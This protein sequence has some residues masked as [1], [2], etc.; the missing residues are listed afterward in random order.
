MA[1]KAKVPTKRIK[2][3][4]KGLRKGLKKEVA[5][6]K[7]AQKKG[8]QTARKVA[9]NSKELI[10]LKK[11]LEA[12]KKKKRRAGLSDYN[13]FMRA[14]IKKGKSFKQAAA[15]WRK[16]K[17]QAAKKLRRPSSYNVFVSMELKR[18]KTM[19]QAIRA[20]NLLK[21]PPKKRRKKPVKKKVVRS[22]IVVR[23][24]KPIVR[25]IVRMSKPK[26]ITRIRRIVS[27]PVV[28][29]K[30][31]FPERKIVAIIKEAMAQSRTNT[32]KSSES[33][34]RIFSEGIP[35]DEEL[36]LDLLELYYSEVAR[37]GVK[38]SL[39]LDEI[40][41]SFFYSLARI[42]RKGI[43]LKEFEEIAKKN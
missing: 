13:R 36:A 41:N 39:N 20:W 18:G 7:K 2:R 22:K 3:E 43:E 32:V 15:I 5:K 29:T 42:Q 28:V 24:R 10:L 23:R 1:V 8:K 9:E 4:I 11:E 19:K 17:K 6:A 30:N 27:K 38:R 26:I 31:V 33:V 34:S 16:M 14:Q 25:T 37:L 35:C 21:N 12:L 40:I